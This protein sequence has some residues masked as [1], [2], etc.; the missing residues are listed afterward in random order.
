MRIT[1]LHRGRLSSP[2]TI[3][4]LRNSSGGGRG[5]GGLLSRQTVVLIQG[6]LVLLST[7]LSILSQEG[8]QVGAISDGILVSGDLAQFD[9]LTPEKK[10]REDRTSKM[11]A[12]RL[13]LFCRAK[14][15]SQT[16]AA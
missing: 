2:F 11:R 12:A 1:D 6:G 16:F 14:P 9:R 4:K 8:L 13:S 10:K 3:G 7:K 15:P 5:G